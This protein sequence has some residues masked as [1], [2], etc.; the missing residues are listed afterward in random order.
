MR[1]AGGRPRASGTPPSLRGALGAREAGRWGAPGPRGG[2]HGIGSLQGDSSWQGRQGRGRW[3]GRSR[4]LKYNGQLE[5]HCGAG[6]GGR[7]L[8]QPPLFLKEKKDTLFFFHVSITNTNE[9]N[10]F[11][12]NKY[13]LSLRFAQGTVPGLRDQATL[14]EPLF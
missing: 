8:G 9:D 2:Q 6:G 10:Y 3:G 4:I 11:L 12:S 14:Q 13:L 7:R 1:P 5:D